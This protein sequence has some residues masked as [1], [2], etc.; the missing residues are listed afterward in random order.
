MKNSAIA[1]LSKV[2][3]NRDAELLR[4]LFT[5]DFKNKKGPATCFLA[6]FFVEFFDENFCYLLPKLP[7]KSISCFMFRHLMTS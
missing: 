4:F 2:F 7:S 3:Q 1:E 5:E 6:T